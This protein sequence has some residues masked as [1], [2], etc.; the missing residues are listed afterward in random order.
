MI[1]F[2]VGHIQH[3]GRHEAVI[4]RKVLPNRS[5]GRR[6]VE[7]S[8]THGKLYTSIG[9]GLTSYVSRARTTKSA[10]NSYCI[11]HSSS[12]S[13]EE[14]LTKLT[15][16]VRKLIVGQHHQAV[17]RVCG[18]C[19]SV[20]HPTNLCPTLQEDELENTKCVGVLGG[21]HQYGRQLYHPNPNQGQHTAP[22]FGQAEGMLVLS[23]GNY[24]VG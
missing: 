13:E 7:S 17:Q 1:V 12:R 9:K 23:Q 11:T 6:S 10:N 20:E 24:Q 18:I 21:R 15:S 3:L 19:T 4:P 5:L 16:L 22:R 2:A 14:L 8:S